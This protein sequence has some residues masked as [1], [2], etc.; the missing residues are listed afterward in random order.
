MAAADVRSGGGR[1]S[2]CRLGHAVHTGRMDKIWKIISS[3]ERLGGGGP[4]LKE[5]FLVAIRDQKNALMTL[6]HKRPDIERS[7]LTVVGEADANYVEWFGVKN[8]DIFC[9][10]AV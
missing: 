10:L 1:N 9:L 8:G 2:A 4:P 5:F 7:E 6:K 3:T